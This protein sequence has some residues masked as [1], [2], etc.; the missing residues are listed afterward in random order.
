[1][2]WLEGQ[3]K[4]FVEFAHKLLVGV[5]LPWH[6]ASRGATHLPDRVGCG[7]GFS[8]MNGATMNELNFLDGEFLDD[9]PADLLIGPEGVVTR[10]GVNLW[11]G[12]SSLSQPGSRLR[13]ALEAAR[14]KARTGFDL[15]E[16]KAWW[17][18]AMRDADKHAQTC[19]RNRDNCIRCR[20]TRCWSFLQFSLR[21]HFTRADAQVYLTMAGIVLPFLSTSADEAL[22]PEISR[23]LQD[24]GKSPVP[25]PQH[26]ERDEEDESGQAAS[27]EDVGDGEVWSE[28]VHEGV[29]SSTASPA[30]LSPASP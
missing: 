1:L 16:G 15:E 20:D 27:D 24:T 18:T 6:K 12:A 2:K 30:S 3:A 10:D 26:E 25:E 8:T 9:L 17:S 4:P 11:A 7:S 22:R 23:L 28:G 21:L 19:R 13:L 5:R 14:I 29:A